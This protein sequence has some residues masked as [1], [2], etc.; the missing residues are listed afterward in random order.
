MNLQK[1]FDVQ[2]EL[3]QFI[4]NKYYEEPSELFKDKILKFIIKIS[5]L[6]N[7]IQ[8][9]KYKEEISCSLLKA[10]ITGFHDLLSL[11]LN[12]GVNTGFLFLKYKMV[13]KGQLDH[14]LDIYTNIMNLNDQPSIINYIEL[15]TSYIQLG[16]L[17][18][19]EVNEIEKVYLDTYVP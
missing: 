4:T 16:Q 3:D 17:L 15:F 6:A 19:L 8:S 13:T 7:E 5:E 14:F 9:N 12:R 18:H 2:K 10:Y 11:G 1:L